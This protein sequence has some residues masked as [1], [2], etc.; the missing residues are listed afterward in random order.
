[1]KTD[2]IQDERIKELVGDYVCLDIKKF[3]ELMGIGRTTFYRLKKQLKL[4]TKVKNK[5]TIIYLNKNNIFKNKKNEL[6]IN[7]RLEN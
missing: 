1:M 2:A 7:K 6:I 5:K 3:C 4:K